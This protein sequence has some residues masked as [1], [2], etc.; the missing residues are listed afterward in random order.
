MEKR[1][2]DARSTLKYDYLQQPHVVE[3]TPLE[4]SGDFEELEVV[5]ELRVPGSRQ[6]IFYSNFRHLSWILRY[7][8]EHTQLHCCE[9]GE[10]HQ[11]ALLAIGNY[12]IDQAKSLGKDPAYVTDCWIEKE[13]G[14][15]V[16]AQSLAGQLAIMLAR[17]NKAHSGALTGFKRDGRLVW[18]THAS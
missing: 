15:H 5:A 10:L 1:Y 4:I 13:L 8:F 7:Q 11:P 12:F 3:F 18:W 6:A 2:K 14:L 17:L 9:F 16:P